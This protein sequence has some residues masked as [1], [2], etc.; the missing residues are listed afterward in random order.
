MVEVLRGLCCETID[1]LCGHEGGTPHDHGFGCVVYIGFHQYPPARVSAGTDALANNLMKG[2][3]MPTAHPN[4]NVQSS[5]SLAC[6]DQITS[7]KPIHNNTPNSR[8]TYKHLSVLEEQNLIC[9]MHDCYVSYVQM[10]GSLRGFITYSYRTLAVRE[11]YDISESTYKRFYTTH[12]RTLMLPSNDV[13]PT[14]DRTQEN[15]H[16]AVWYELIDM[17]VRL[18]YLDGYGIH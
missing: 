5:S 10:Q 16:D 8:K 13:K 7:V 18:H 17:A 14:P 3:S 1:R 4:H 6:P 11:R 12:K 2:V 9:E 15:E